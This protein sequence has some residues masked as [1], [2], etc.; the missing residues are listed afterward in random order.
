MSK[1]REE[2]TIARCPH[3]SAS[4]TY[5]LDVERSV[6]MHLMTLGMERAAPTRRTFTRLFACPA[7]NEH[8]E[9]D[10]TLIESASDRIQSV[11]VAEAVEKPR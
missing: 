9:A 3:C 1:S 7:K 2:V 11:S 6:V 10:V 5:A 4:H 8:Y